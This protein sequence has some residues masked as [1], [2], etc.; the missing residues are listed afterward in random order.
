VPHRRLI[1]DSDGWFRSLPR[2]KSLYPTH[3]TS[4]NT[5]NKR[6]PRIIYRTNH[7]LINHPTP[8]H[9]TSISPTKLPP[10]LPSSAPN[11]NQPIMPSS[12]TTSKGYMGLIPLLLGGPPPL[13]LAYHNRRKTNSVSTMALPHDYKSLT[14]KELNE[15]LKRLPLPPNPSYLA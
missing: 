1:L 5:T 9:H 7:A 4:Y 11:P 13:P 2:T 3:I 14:F 15:L 10:S 12:H 8:S 6:T